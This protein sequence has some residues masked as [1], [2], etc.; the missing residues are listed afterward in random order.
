[1]RASTPPGPSGR[2]G[3][4]GEDVAGRG[5]LRRHD[6]PP[7]SRPGGQPV[8]VRQLLLADRRRPA[9]GAAAPAAVA[10]P[11][12]HDRSRRGRRTPR[13]ARTSS[14]SSLPMASSS[15][16]AR[17][18]CSPTPECSVTSS[19][20]CPCTG[21]TTPT[22]P[23]HAWSPRFTTPTEAAT[24]ISSVRTPTGLATADKEFFVSPFNEIDGCYRMWLPEP[25]RRLSLTVTL[26]RTD[27]APFTA[28]VRGERLAADARTLVRLATRHPLAPLVGSLRIRYQGLK[29]ALM[30]LQRVTHPAAEQP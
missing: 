7:P 21:A 18:R 11:L 12:R 15:T 13:F 25:G 5:A 24:A 23:W 14:R 19:I 10:G 4:V 9:A 2:S 16:V 26:D 22:A 6:Q 29:L 20:R 1:M 3:E 27:H 17:S 8:R 28:T 30:G